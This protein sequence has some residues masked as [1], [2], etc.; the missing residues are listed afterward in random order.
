MIDI[1]KVTLKYL[2]SAISIPCYMEEP[3]NQPDSYIVIEKTGS[4][5]IET[6]VYGAM[7]AVQCY[8]KSLLEAHE[9]NERMKPYMMSFQDK[10]DGVAESRLNTDYNFTDSETKRYRYQAIFD[11]V[12]Y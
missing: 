10:N 6:G 4:S 11:I 2:E 12:H 1:C 9:L 7:I 5:V 3:I 8:G